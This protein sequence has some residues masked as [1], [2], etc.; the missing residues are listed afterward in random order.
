MSRTI[1]RALATLAISLAVGGGVAAGQTKTTSETKTFE[2]IAV[3][4][5]QLVVKLPE[6]TREVTVPPDFRFTVDGQQM[7]LQQLKPGM[8][9]MAT[10]TTRETV[11]PVTVTEVKNGEVMQASGATIIVRTE[12]GIKMFT[13]GDVDKRGVKIMRNGQRA[14]IADLRAGDKLTATIMTA[15]P[16]RVLTDKEVTATLARTNAPAASPAARASTPS[17][18]PAEREPSAASRPAPAATAGSSAAASPR[19]LPKTASSLPTMLATG[20]VLLMAGGLLRARRR[21]L[22]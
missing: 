2:V 11:S 16:P 7:S 12:D 5:N 20:L 18:A 6:G 3:Y 14:E 22:Q 10:I 17:A 15:K 8:K 4:G 21:R 9:G 19:T 1:A 13:Q